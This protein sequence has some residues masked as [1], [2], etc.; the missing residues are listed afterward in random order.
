MG[1][2]YP[3]EIEIPPSI[4]RTSLSSC[5][6]RNSLMMTGSLLLLLLRK[7]WLTSMANAARK[8]ELSND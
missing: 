2:S 7:L 1:C 8:I 6:T 3:S 5:H 4:A